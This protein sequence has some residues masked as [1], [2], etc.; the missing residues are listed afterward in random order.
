MSRIPSSAA[1]G[2]ALGCVLLAGLACEE[3]GRTLPERCNEPALKIYDIL[4]A[5][6]PADDNHQYNND[7]DPNDPK[8]ILPCL[9]EVGHSISSVG[10]N[11]PAPTPTDGGDGS[12]GTSSS[13]SGGKASGGVGGV[14]G[15]GGVAGIGGKK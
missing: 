6:A 9:T 12:G 13:G 5:G 10:G 2:F 8:K 15:L 4:A 3:D 14:A 7:K 11:S 1:L